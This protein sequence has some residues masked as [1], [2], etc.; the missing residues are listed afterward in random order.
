MPDEQPN[1][2]DTK[3]KETD[4]TS[5]ETTEEP[6]KPLSLYEKTE[7]IVTRQEEANK[8]TEELLERQEKLHA[9]Q[10]LAGT[11]GGNVPVKTVSPEDKKTENAKEFFKDTALGDAI[12]KSMKKNE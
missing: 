1:A 7:A 4:S 6:D 12:A 9:N 10:R 11:G 5:K 2:P 8:K 3:G